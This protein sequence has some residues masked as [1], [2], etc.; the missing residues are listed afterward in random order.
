MRRDRSQG[1]RQEAAWSGGFAPPPAW[2]PFGD[3]ATQYG[4][5]SFAEPLRR[6][7]GPLLATIVKLGDGARLRLVR[8]GHRSLRAV[9]ALA[10]VSVPR[11]VATALA[12]LVLAASA[13]LVAP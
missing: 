11:S 7:L 5:A 4:P 10:A 8:L 9:Q 3:P 2:L 13:W 1:H 6:A 12:L